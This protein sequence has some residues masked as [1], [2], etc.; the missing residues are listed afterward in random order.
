MCVPTQPHTQYSHQLCTQPQAS[1]PIHSHPHQKSFSTS[2]LRPYTATKSHT[3]PPELQVG[4]RRLGS[5]HELF[6][7]LRGTQF[8]QTDWRLVSP[9][10]HCQYRLG[11]IYLWCGVVWCGV[12]WCGVVWCGVVWWSVVWCGVVWF[13]V[14]WCGVV[15][16]GVVWCGVVWCCVVWCGVVWCGVVWCRVV[17]VGDLV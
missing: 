3:P 8:V 9:F 4:V 2:H 7:E 6:D 14:V 13:G 5:V 17:D 10:P 1:L 16:F 12:V 11:P 15:W